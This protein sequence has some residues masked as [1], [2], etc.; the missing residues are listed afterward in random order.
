MDKGCPG[1]FSSFYQQDIPLVNAKS[2][3]W[4]WL[5]ETPRARRTTLTWKGVVVAERWRLKEIFCL[6]QEAADQET[7]R[8]WAVCP[9]AVGG[10]QEENSEK[11]ATHS[12][13]SSCSESYTLGTT[14]ATSIPPPSSVQDQAVA[15]AC[16]VQEIPST[17]MDT[18][19]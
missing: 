19:T 11:G 2:L 16:R 17:G 10:L 4:L 1:A 8:T 15:M 18:L 13:C 3:L 14:E 12:G 7:C 9:Q 5:L 6:L